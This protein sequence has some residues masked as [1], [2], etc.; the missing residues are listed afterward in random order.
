[1][2]DMSPSDSELEQD[3]GGFFAISEDLVQSPSHKP[4][5]QQSIDFDGA[6]DPPLLVY[7][8]LVKGNGGQVWVAGMRL[9]KYLLRRKRDELR[10]AGSMFVLHHEK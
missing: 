6:L 2:P 3:D 7:E 10:G 9:A 4:A 1:M 8:D 5:G